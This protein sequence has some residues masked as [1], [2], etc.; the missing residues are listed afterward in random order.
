MALSNLNLL[1]LGAKDSKGP[2]MSNSSSQDP[3]GDAWIKSSILQE[4][5]LLRQHVERRFQSKYLKVV[6]KSKNDEEES[7]AWYGFYHWLTLPETSRKPF[8][9]PEDE[10]DII[11]DSLRYTVLNFVNSNKQQKETNVK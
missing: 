3:F 1:D 10:A 2:R 6:L 8:Q 5:D 11:I 4:D 9:I 7:R